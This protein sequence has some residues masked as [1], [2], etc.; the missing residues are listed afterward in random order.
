MY[1]NELIK[2]YKPHEVDFVFPKTKDTRAYLDLYHLYHSPDKRWQKVQ[3]LVF[4]YFNYH[5]KLHRK[6]EISEDKL[7]EKLN[8]PEVPYIALGHCKNGIYGSGS[9]DDRA[10]VIKESIFDNEEIGRIGLEALA[11]NS[12]TMGG[13]GPDL[14]SDMVANL[15]MHYLIEYTHEQVE[16]YSLKT[17]EFQIK[18]ALTLPDFEWVPLTRVKLP[19]FKNGEPRIFVPRHITK[20]LPIFTTSSFYDNYLKYLL[21]EEKGDRVRSVKTIGKKPKISLDQIEA[22]LKKKYGTLGEATRE[23]GLKRQNILTHYIKNPL[24]Y[25]KAHSRKL[26]EKVNWNNYSKELASIKLGREGARKY[27]ETLR[28]IFTALYRDGLVNG[29]LEERSEGN[30]FFYDITFA[31]ASETAFFKFLRNQQI[32]AGVIIVEAKNYDKT[33]VSNEQINQANGYGIVDGREF[34]MLITRDL[35]TD[36][37]IEKSRRIFLTHRILVLPVS[38]SDVHKLLEARFK[39]PEEFDHLLIERAQQILQA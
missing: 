9:A 16:L 38:D 17:A 2:K 4:E 23:I 29:L 5:L 35:I 22:E 21:Q 7:I 36:K 24:A 15:G 33:K 31:N 10:A 34:V 6:G 18:R 12:I 25:K 28:K 32:K 8:F 19:I 39:N 26:V 37:L 20:R 13:W 1:L 3:A 11:S 14:L 30:M 27:A